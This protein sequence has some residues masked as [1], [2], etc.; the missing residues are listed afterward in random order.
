MAFS[1]LVR[2]ELVRSPLPACVSCIRAELAAM[3]H[4]SGSIHLT[5]QEQLAL[6]VT[7]DTAGGARRFVR[8]MKQSSSLIAEIRVETFERLGHH[9]R[10]TIH[11]SSQPG[12]NYFLQKLGLLDRE[13]RPESSI[14]A[15]LVTT[16]CCRASFIKG[17]F[18]AGGSITAPEKK[19]YHLEIV[20]VSEE[21]AEGLAHVM[22]LLGLKARVSLRKERYMVYLKEGEAIA[23]LLTLINAHGAV[24]HMEETRVIKGMRGDV[25]RLVNCETA[26][27]EKTLVA[28]WE[29]VELITRFQLTRRLE[30]LLPSLHDIA[31]LRLEYPEASLKELGEYHSPPL[32]KSAV[33]HRLRQ[34]REHLKNNDY[35]AG[36]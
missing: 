31:R 2:E 10:Y 24:L 34:L 28:A 11:I 6:S 36:K 30:E 23:R 33:N 22:N 19:T 21:F 27:L 4:I 32:S 15:E 35:E 1:Q 12:L 18:L 3:L 25:N 8:L 13:L 9:H 17:A 26:N 7:L 5:G 20:T 29:Q 14:R 16:K